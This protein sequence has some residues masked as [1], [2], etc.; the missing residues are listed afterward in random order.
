MKCGSE[1]SNTSQKFCQECGH[2]IDEHTSIES[3][4]TTVLLQQTQENASLSDKHFDAKK[5][6]TLSN[7]KDNVDSYSKRALVF[8]LLSFLISVVFF[9]VNSIT[10]NIVYAA[11]LE[12]HQK[13]LI[14]ILISVFILIVSALGLIFGIVGKVQASRTSSDSGVGKAGN[15]FSIIGIVINSILLALNIF[16]ILLLLPNTFSYY[17]MHG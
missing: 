16:M 12:W 2:P 9:I 7:K 1:I 13:N 17:T 10:T 3:S 5:I 6:S 15:V 11:P 4:S 14:D 8:G